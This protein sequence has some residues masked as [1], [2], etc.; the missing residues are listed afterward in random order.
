MKMYLLNL[1]FSLLSPLL[2]FLRNMLEK[3]IS[4]DFFWKRIQGAM[5]DFVEGP[6]PIISVFLSTPLCFAQ[7]R[8]SKFGATCEHGFRFPMKVTGKNPVPYDLNMPKTWKWVYFIVLVLIQHIP[9]P[10]T[11]LI[12]K[13]IRCHM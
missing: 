3:W 11:R 9:Q 12:G 7:T 2:T 13:L 1:A 5:C 8:N 4:T 10:S 6:S